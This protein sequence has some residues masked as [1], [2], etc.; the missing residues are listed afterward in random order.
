VRQ[1]LREELSEVAVELA[2]VSGEHLMRSIEGI[3]A[4]HASGDTGESSCH[5]VELGVG[6]QEIRVDHVSHEAPHARRQRVKLFAELRVYELDKLRERHLGEIRPAI[7]ESVIV[8]E[9]DQDSGETA[10][11]TWDP[12][13]AAR[14]H[15]VAIREGVD[16]PVEENP[17][18]DLAFVT[19][20]RATL[21]EV[22]HEIPDDR[23][24]RAVG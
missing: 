16:R 15:F 9:I 4:P 13:T 12:P 14:E 24:T 2:R 8:E 21:H 6:N 20:V 7:R 11:G 22:P 1:E 19:I 23:P 10:I 3:P 18:E 17:S 5:A